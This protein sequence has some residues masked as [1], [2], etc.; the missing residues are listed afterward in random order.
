MRGWAGG[1][2]SQTWRSEK[3][4]VKG[5][6]HHAVGHD[7][8]DTWDREE[9]LRDR[10]TSHAESAAFPKAALHTAEVS[11]RTSKGPVAAVSPRF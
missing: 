5:I 9:R 2:G 6:P 1:H 10:V 8:E 3:E 7:P 11:H 4:G